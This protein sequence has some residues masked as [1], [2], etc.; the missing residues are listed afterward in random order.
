M[1]LALLVTDFARGHQAQSRSSL[2]MGIS[3]RSAREGL[4]VGTAVEGMLGKTAIA[5]DAPTAAG[6]MAS[7]V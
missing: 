2:P 3:A 4:G 7:G 5:A 6:D 1:H